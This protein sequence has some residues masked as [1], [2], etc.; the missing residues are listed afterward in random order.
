MSDRNPSRLSHAHERPDLR[1]DNPMYER[2]GSAQTAFEASSKGEDAERAARR[3][4]FMVKRQEPKPVLRPSP[5]LAL[6]PDGA[7][8]DA[9]WNEER[10]RA[11]PVSNALDSR[12]H[13]ERRMTMDNNHPRDVLRDGSLKASIWRNETADK[14]PFYSASLARTYKDEASGELRDS[15]SFAGTELLRVAELARKA[16]DRTQELRREHRDQVA[17][18]SQQPAQDHNAQRAP[19][20]DGS[21]PTPQERQS[22][23]QQANLPTPERQSAQPEPARNAP[24]VDP[25]REQRRQEFQEQRQAVP[26]PTQGHTRQQ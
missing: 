16:Y 14:G 9:Q 19:V 2:A 20:R 26:A 18:E 21:A 25:A 15:H 23:P 10:R 4:S 22:Q 24:I 13:L 5:S 7:A 11:R 12:D 3:D 8:F 17:H 6:G 1:A